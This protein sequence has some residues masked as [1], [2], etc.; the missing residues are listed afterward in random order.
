LWAVPGFPAEH[1]E[2]LLAPP[3]STTHNL[4][5]SEPML[6]IVSLQFAELFRRWHFWL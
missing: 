1:G 5:D 2:G 4:R 6:V 3:E